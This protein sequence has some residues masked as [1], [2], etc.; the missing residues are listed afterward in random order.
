MGRVSWPSQ[1]GV[2]SSLQNRSAPAAACSPAQRGQGSGA[3]RWRETLRNPSYGA[4]PPP[5]H[6]HGVA[7]TSTVTMSM[8]GSHQGLSMNRRSGSKGDLAGAGNYNYARSEVVHGGGNGYEPYVDGYRTYTHSKSTKGGTGGGMTTTERMVSGRMSGVGS[9]MAGGMGG[10][11]IGSMAGGMGGGTMSGV[12]SGMAG[13][14]GGGMGGG[15]MTSTM[16]GMGSGMAG[17]MGSGM[18]SGTMSGMGG[19]MR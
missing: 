15:M 12:G 4:Y 7:A 10:G 2:V 14:M 17:G 9:G 11:M 16:S 13:G 3:H 8:Y 18:M 5:A 6:L 19:G 1:R